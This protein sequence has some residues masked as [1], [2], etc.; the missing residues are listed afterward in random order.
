MMPIGSRPRSFR[1]SWPAYAQET[2]DYFAAAIDKTLG[3][4]LEAD[5]NRVRLVPSGVEIQRMEQA[6]AW[7]AHYLASRA[8]LLVIVQEVACQRAHS[9]TASLERIA[10]RLRRSPGYLRRCNRAGLDLI[11]AGLRRDNVAMF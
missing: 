3:I 1:T 11:A 2:V 5:R 8:M 9:A 7:P 6:I 4:E 10:R